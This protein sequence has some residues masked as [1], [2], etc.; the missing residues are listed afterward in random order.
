MQR[1][2]IAQKR[3]L[4]AVTLGVDTVLPVTQRRYDLQFSRLDVFLEEAA[5]LTFLMFLQYGAWQACVLWVLLNLQLGYDLQLLG[6]GDVANLLASLTHKL[7]QATRE[8]SSQVRK[9]APR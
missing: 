4:P 1:R 6:V 8:V 7:D 9:V 5:G 3:S 2:Q